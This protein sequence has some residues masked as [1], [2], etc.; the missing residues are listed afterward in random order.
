M[1]GYMDCD[2]VPLHVLLVVGFG[3]PVFSVSTFREGL[4]GLGLFAD[5]LDFSD[6]EEDWDK[7]LGFDGGASGIYGRWR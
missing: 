2:F 7:S 4:E 1:V 3:A 5:E 6:M